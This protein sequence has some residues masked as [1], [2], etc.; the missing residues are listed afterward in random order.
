MVF[1]LETSVED[2]RGCLIVYCSPYY[3][4]RRLI[5][6]ET[7]CQTTVDNAHGR[8]E[9]DGDKN[10]FAPGHGRTV[11]YLELTKNGLQGKRKI[12]DEG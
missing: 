4:F 10:R 11:L 6:E 1:S 12:N 2:F 7:R 5:S 8:C 3:F 9:D